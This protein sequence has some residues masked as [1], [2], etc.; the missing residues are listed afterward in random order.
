[1]FIYGLISIF[2][3]CFLPGLAILGLINIKNIDRVILTFPTSLL[4]NYLLV[5]ILTLS[6]WYTKEVLVVIVIIECVF[7]LA[8]YT[9]YPKS[10]LLL[11]GPTS[12]TQ[13]DWKISP[14]LR[15]VFFLLAMIVTCWLAIKIFK[16]IPSNF[17][18]YDDTCNWNRWASEWYRGQLP[19]RT[20]EYPQLLP[21]NWSINYILMGTYEIEYFV[22]FING[23]M[24]IYVLGAFWAMYLDTRYD[25]FLVSISVAGLWMYFLLN[26]WIGVGMADVPS[27]F[28][29]V[30]MLYTTHLGLSSKIDIKQ[31]LVLGA[32]ITSGAALTK[33]AGNYLVI[34]YLCSL[35]YLAKKNQLHVKEIFKLC[36]KGLSIV[37]VLAWSWYIYHRILYAHGLERSNIYYVTQVIF[38]G[39]SYWERFVIANIEI[40]NS[41][42]ALDLIWPRQIIFNVGA[43]L[44]LILIFFS[45][46]SPLGALS[47][48]VV[49]VP[50]YMLWAVFFSY[51][52]NQRNFGLGVGFLSFSTASG[53]TYFLAHIIPTLYRKNSRA[54]KLVFTLLLTVIISTGLYRLN[55]AINRES[56][57]KI[58]IDFL[59]ERS[60]VYPPMYSLYEKGYFTGKVF[61]TYGC[62]RCNAF[63]GTHELVSSMQPDDYPSLKKLILSGDYHY[64]LRYNHQY[65]PA[66]YDQVDILV[67]QGRLLKK[68]KWSD[69]NEIFILYEIKA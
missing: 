55:I 65:S 31:F 42:S 17:N 66:A 7:I 61:T 28:F 3:I 43:I 16:K 10:R 39:K 53:F 68:Y 19:F 2:Q 52:H 62:D 30:M 29:G 32:I 23:L 6:G 20:W 4:A 40:R 1:M 36:A 35:I 38:E 47:S 8:I 33:Q 49:T 64:Y 26:Q 27:A 44:T 50:F 14:F 12:I 67:Q 45:L 54:F 46:Q 60:I 24:P 13:P 34:F 15:Q 58:K 22:T 59:R 9:K 57:T 51:G 25:V 18:G 11:E 5:S 37:L 48:I 41:I 56:L 21:T 69:S 63:P